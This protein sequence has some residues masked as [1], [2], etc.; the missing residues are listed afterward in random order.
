M[1]SPVFQL[2]NI[3]TDGYAD[4]RKYHPGIVI[5]RKEYHCYAMFISSLI[6]ELIHIYIAKVL[7]DRINCYTHGK[8]FKAICRKVKK[9]LPNIDIASSYWAASLTDPRINKRINKL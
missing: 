9:A 8:V 5:L 1:I 7:G 4:I 3:K 6:H 2:K